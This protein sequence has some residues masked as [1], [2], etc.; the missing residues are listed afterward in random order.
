MPF[1]VKIFGT[2]KE[3]FCKTKL[4]SM[5][6]FEILLVLPIDLGSQYK[7]QI[8]L[9]SSVSYDQKNSKIS[10]PNLLYPTK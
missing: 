10:V 8:Y 7:A 6:Y 3:R 5:V 1:G 4:G 2:F 9:K